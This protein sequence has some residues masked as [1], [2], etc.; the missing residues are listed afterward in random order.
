MDDVGGA[1]AG[2]GDSKQIKGLLNCFT[3]FV[4]DDGV[5]LLIMKVSR[6]RTTD[7]LNCN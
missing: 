1:A 5:K 3:A 4:K 2:G 6:A 7:R